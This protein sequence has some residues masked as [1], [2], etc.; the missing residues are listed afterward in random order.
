MKDQK[1]KTIIG[2]MLRFVAFLLAIALA[3]QVITPPV[4]RV[5][6][7]MAAG[8]DPL[9]KIYNILS[10][11]VGEPE[12][13]QDYYELAT[14]SIGKGEYEN[15]LQQLETARDMLNINNSENANGQTEVDANK[16]KQTEVENTQSGIS[17]DNDNQLLSEIW[18]KTAS[19]YVLMG[20]YD[21]AQNAL[22]ETLLIDPDASQALLL[23]GQLAIE[24]SDYEAAIADIEKYLELNPTDS[25]TRQSLAQI[26]E[27]TAD[28]VKAVEQYE[29]LYE[30]IPSDESFKLNA[31]RCLFLSGQYTEAI[32]GF[33][34][35]KQRHVEDVSDPYGGIADF[36][37]AACL[38]QTGDY[39]AAAEGFEMAIEAGYDKA[40]C[41]EQITLCAFENGEYEKVI[42]VGEE[43]FTL[44]NPALSAPAL[45]YQ[46]MGISAMR[47]GD[48]ESALSDMDQAAQIDAKL[49]G[50]EYYRGVC[51]LSLERLEEA[52]EA[53]GASIENGYLPQFC[54]YNRG[55]C[56]VQLL[57]Y[58]KAI[59]DM[60]MTLEAGDDADL[61]VAAKDILWQL[62]TYYDQTGSEA[63]TED[64]A[65]AENEEVIAE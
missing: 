31:L 65:D 6:S 43:I 14:I 64:A 18:L 40:T 54:Y 27:S 57:E 61:I 62:A 55:V 51:L 48:Y 15:A 36:L 4:A 13:A 9:S 32:A 29:T 22:N 52:V 21:D 5:I 35:Y 20:K 16:E 33:D 49:E 17:E 30:Q 12:T 44:E 46:R 26:F 28:Y 25:T 60:A 50:N 37:R 11:N 58:E 10:D 53:F 24:G 1:Q 2:K 7:A 45:V 19:V 56:Y 63:S 42:S 59:D 39:A 38:M 23:R 3:W 47:M 41:L 8:N 34:D